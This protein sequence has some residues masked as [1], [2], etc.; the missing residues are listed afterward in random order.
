MEKINYR[1]KLCHQIFLNEGAL[2]LCTNL[3]L[4]DSHTAPPWDR[5]RCLDR[6]RG[7]NERREPSVAVLGYSMPS[8]TGFLDP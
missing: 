4:V 7:K 2:N 3:H 5:L 8:E 6:T 1:L